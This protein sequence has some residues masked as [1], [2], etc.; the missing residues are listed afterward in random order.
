MMACP[1]IKLSE[2]EDFQKEVTLALI[3]DPNLN[4]GRMFLLHY[5]DVEQ[6]LM[7]NSNLGTPAGVY[8]PSND[9]ILNSWKRSAD[10]AYSFITDMV[11]IIEDA[12]WVEYVDTI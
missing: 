12:D 10:D 1:R 5:P 6:A 7:E 8:N 11:E 3:R 9:M 4:V 2:W